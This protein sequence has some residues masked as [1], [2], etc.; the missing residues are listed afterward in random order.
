MNESTRVLVGLGVGL[1]TGLAIAASHNPTLLHA[2]NALAPI[3]TVCVNAIRMTV[4]RQPSKPWPSAGGSL[5]TGV[6]VLRAG[7]EDVTLV[8]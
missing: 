7:R 4:I 6:V 5:G 3:G 8:N 2:A 1:G